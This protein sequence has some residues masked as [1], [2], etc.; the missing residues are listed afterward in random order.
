MDTVRVFCEI[1]GRG[2]ERKGQHHALIPN[3]AGFEIVGHSLGSRSDLAREFE[4]AFSYS[5]VNT[6]YY[7]HFGSV[8]INK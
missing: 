2:Y 4:I 5:L 8:I 1:Q 3:I 6:L 7:T